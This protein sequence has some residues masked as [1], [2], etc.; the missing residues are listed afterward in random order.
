MGKSLH[1]SRIRKSLGLGLNISARIV[2]GLV[3]RNDGTLKITSNEKTKG[4]KIYFL[5]ENQLSLRD[6]SLR[7]PMISEYTTKNNTYK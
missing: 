7:N 2:E 6:E 4:T 3:S 5:I 1:R